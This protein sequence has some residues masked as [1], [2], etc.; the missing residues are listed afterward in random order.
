[1]IPKQLHQIW[2]GSAEMKEEHR[3][4]VQMWRDMYPDFVHRLWGNEDIASVLPPEKKKYFTPE[5]PIALRADL[6]RY[7]IIR[8]HGG[9]YVDVDTEPLKRMEFSPDTRF[10]SGVQ[11]NGQVAIG[12]FGAEPNNPLMDDVCRS[13]LENIETRLRDGCLWENVDQLTGPDFF[14]R[15]CLPYTGVPGFKF[16]A[17]EVFYPYSWDEPHRRFE[18]FKRT[19]PDAYS[20]HHWAKQW[21]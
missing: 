11:P 2:I 15:M 8:K 9:V 1:M 5:Y 4:F 19:C 7:E 18:D 10:F 20:V 12:I 14:T 17:P 3:A 13:V 6:L 16:A 21:R